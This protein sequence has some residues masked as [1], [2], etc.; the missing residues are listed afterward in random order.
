MNARS[1]DLS[2]VLSP[3]ARIALSVLEATDDGVFAVDRRQRVVFW[4]RGAERLLGVPRDRALG[5]F[6]YE[7]MVGRDPEGHPFCR[8][9]CPT[10]VAARRGRPV[11][12]YD[13]Q[14]PG[15]GGEPLWLNMTIVPLPERGA[16]GAIH[17][18]RDVTRRRLAEPLAEK[19][20]IS[21]RLRRNGDGQSALVRLPPLPLLSPRER[22]VLRALA[23]G[24][25]T[26]AIASQLG[27]SIK[28]ARNHIERTIAKLGVHTRVQ[29]VVFAAHHHL[30]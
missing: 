3:R 19:G 16:P 21:L 1:A 12:N 18:F 22:E 23:A 10:I 8:R 7:L 27:I 25:D 5:R 2:R 26:A 4:S 29:A 6:C 14:C 9:D 17:I 13:L 30:L 24:L 15:A 28:T 11:P 20:Q